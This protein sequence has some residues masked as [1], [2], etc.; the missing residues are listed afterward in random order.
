ASGQDFCRAQCR[1]REIGKGV[2]TALRRHRFGEQL[3]PAVPP[4][5]RIEGGADLVRL[6]AEA[7]EVSMLELDAGAAAVCTKRTSTSVSKSRSY[8]QFPLICQASTT[9]VGG[10][11]VS[12]RPHSHSEP[13][14]LRSYQRPPACGSTMTSCCADLVLSECCLGHH[15]PIP[16]VKT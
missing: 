6:V 16:D 2:T 5:R 9:R 1:L 7:L 15:L 13:S 11:Q 14:S 12:T 8:C 3:Q 10:S 4:F